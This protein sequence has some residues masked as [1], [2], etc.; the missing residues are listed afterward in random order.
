MILKKKKKTDFWHLYI[1]PQGGVYV[2][3]S[4]NSMIPPN[5]KKKTNQPIFKMITTTPKQNCGW[6]PHRFSAATYPT[7]NSMP[8][9]SLLDMD[10]LFRPLDHLWCHVPSGFTAQVMSSGSRV[11][12][13][14]PGE[15]NSMAT[16]LWGSNTANDGNQLRLV[17]YPTIYRGLY[18]PG[19]AGFQQSTVSLYVLFLCKHRKWTICR[20]VFAE[21]DHE[22]AL[23][24]LW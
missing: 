7:T 3:L 10:A 23:W 24:P 18:I 14:R 9:N 5:Q 21:K 1:P 11:V 17:V 6:K 22:F 16:N 20:C 4:I 2:D 13:F 8:W 15:Y 12:A 19:G